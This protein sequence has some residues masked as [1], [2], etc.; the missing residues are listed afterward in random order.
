[1]SIM[2]RHNRIG[3]IM[4]F[5]YIRAFIVLLAGLI[6]II[7]NIKTH[8]NVTLSLL[9][10]LIVLII[11]YFVATLLVEILQHF[12]ERFEP[13]SQTEPQAMETA[14]ETMSGETDDET[15]YTEDSFYDEE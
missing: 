10:L 1:M 7:L 5:R 12:M 13:L 14:E 9:I 2:N 4:K 15:E 11:F 3:W 6:T 8:R